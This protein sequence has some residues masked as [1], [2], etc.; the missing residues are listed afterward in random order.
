M[1]PAKVSGPQEAV[2]L[3]EEKYCDCESS[4]CNFKSGEIRRNKRSL[5]ISVMLSQPILALR[6]NCLKMK[7]EAP[8]MVSKHSQNPLR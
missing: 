3:E 8:T 2:D 7:V 1:P 4:V 6:F 5:C